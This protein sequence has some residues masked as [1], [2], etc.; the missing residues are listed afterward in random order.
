MLNA[1]DLSEDFNLKTDDMETMRNTSKFGSFLGPIREKKYNVE[2]AHREKEVKKAEKLHYETLNYR[3]DLLDGSKEQ[4]IAFLYKQH[5]VQ[6]FASS[7]HQF[8]PSNHHTK[9]A[10]LNARE[11]RWKEQEFE[12]RFRRRAARDDCERKVLRLESSSGRTFYDL[13]GVKHA[14]SSKEIQQAFR[15]MSRK[16]H[17]DKCK[18]CIF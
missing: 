10:F 12:E 6:H 14:A 4:S 13:L 16:Y 7:S 15:R 11:K 1:E 2:C 17:P 3:E 9:K 18:V 8:V 5:C